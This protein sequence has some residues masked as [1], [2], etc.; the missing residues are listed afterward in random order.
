MLGIFKK[1]KTSGAELSEE[2]LKQVSTAINN[3]LIS[4][5]QGRIFDDIYVHAD[6]PNGRPRIT[7]VMFSPSI[8]NQAIA[9][10]AIVLDRI[11]GD[12]PVWQIDWAVLKQHRGQGY[13]MSVAAKALAEF[14]NGMR[15]RQAHGFII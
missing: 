1:K 12:T 9:R 4:L 8:Q 15:E 3:N 6:T 13:G 7:Y 5:E 2:G 11:Q 10:C 14:I